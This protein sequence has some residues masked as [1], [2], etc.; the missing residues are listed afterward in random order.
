MN[1]KSSWFSVIGNC[2]S[3]TKERQ[4]KKLQVTLR[5]STNTGLHIS[6]FLHEKPFNNVEELNSSIMTDQCPEHGTVE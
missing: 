3:K 2:A 6:Y 1:I 4:C 5:P